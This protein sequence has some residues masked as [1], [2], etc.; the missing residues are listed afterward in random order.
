MMSLH[1]EWTCGHRAGPVCGDCHQQLIEKSNAL[2][3]ENVRLKCGLDEAIK[4]L[5]MLVSWKDY[6]ED[7][8]KDEAYRQGKEKAWDRARAV[9]QA[10][11]VS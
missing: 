4:S 6:K 9:V 8:G 11:L 1:D 5:S 2:A 3:A 10:W 7:H